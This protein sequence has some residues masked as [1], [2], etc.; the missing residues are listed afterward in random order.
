LNGCEGAVCMKNI[1]LVG[2]G[3]TLVSISIAQ[4]I[5]IQEK[6]G[7]MAE[8]PQPRQ[9][10]RQSSLSQ[11]AGSENVL[12]TSGSQLTVPTANTVNPSPTGGGGK[13]RRSLLNRFL[14]KSPTNEA[15]VAANNAK[16]D[17][18]EERDL[19]Q[20]DEEEVIT[21]RRR[22]SQALSPAGFYSRLSFWK[23]IDESKTV[24]PQP[25]AVPSAPPRR[26][27]SGL[28]FSAPRSSSAPPVDSSAMASKPA[29][30]PNIFSRRT[31]KTSGDEAPSMQVLDSDS[32]N[33]SNSTTPKIRIPAKAPGDLDSK[34]VLSPKAP[35][36]VLDEDSKVL[37]EAS[38]DEKHEDEP[39]K[40]VHEENS[41]SQS[42]KDGQELEVPVNVASPSSSSLSNVSDEPLSGAESPSGMIIQT[43]DASPKLT[44]RKM[45]GKLPS[46][47]LVSKDK[48]QSG[49]RATSPDM[50]VRSNSGMLN[51]PGGRLSKSQ[52]ADYL[53]Q[54]DNKGGRRSSTGQM[55]TAKRRPQAK[56]ISQNHAKPVRTLRKRELNNGVLVFE[57][58]VV[59]ADTI[60]E[61]KGP[62]EEKKMETSPTSQDTPQK[63][64]RI[65]M[66]SSGIGEDEMSAQ[67]KERLSKKDKVKAEI[68]E[69]EKTYC[70]GLEIL[71]NEFQKPMA[72]KADDL[73]ITAKE[74][75][76]VFSN[77]D[78]I[79]RFHTVMVTQLTS[80]K[81]MAK[82]FSKNADF[83][84]MY[85]QYLNGYEQA[86]EILTQHTKNKKFQSFLA[87]KRD[88]E[89][90]KGL[91]I[92]SY[93]IMPVQRIPRYEL[94]LRELKKYTLPSDEEFLE[95][96]QA[97]DKIQKIA[98]HINENKRQI[99]QLSRLLQI[100]NRLHGKED[101]GFE[102]ISPDRHV[103]RNVH[104]FGFND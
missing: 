79:H 46:A 4:K 59:S 13:Q 38:I 75:S 37:S 22:I 33:G 64:K 34:V 67:E 66:S 92:M 86:I 44:G 88:S 52:Y 16:L 2:Q 35:T 97:F 55:K 10:Q 28:K 70:H 103:L 76:V 36:S 100:E 72:T 83:L 50:P 91:D 51:R 82:V 87:E 21:E 31:T 3:Q 27:A 32:E 77:V 65:R 18:D 6:K 17:V 1:I 98:V 12:R 53:E 58:E 54:F 47:I 102:I 24:G 71:V 7:V 68:I 29:R 89:V 20:A 94:L 93:L 73:G 45:V 101:I 26:A 25:V 62:E 61:E 85:T 5:Q 96:Q 43:P 15:S 40:E 42:A 19:A 74:V 104:L 78:T 56:K 84:K 8:Q 69:T 30:S 11:G 9:H 39:S 23:N 99:E 90:C 57:L 48:R 95:L 60:P 63:K 81:N 41:V 80:E 49:G 14:N